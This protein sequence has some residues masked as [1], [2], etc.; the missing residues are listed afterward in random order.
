[1]LFPTINV[2]PPSLI[3]V[4]CNGNKRLAVTTG[5]TLERQ[6]LTIHIILSASSYRNRQWECF[7]SPLKICFVIIEK[8]VALKSSH[9]LEAESYILF[10]GNF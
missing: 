8:S 9:S 3:I 2:T 7:E 1:M 6:I 4:Y 10:G 5:F